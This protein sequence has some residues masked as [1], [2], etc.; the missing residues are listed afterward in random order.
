MKCYLQTFIF[1]FF[2][3][4]CAKVMAPTGGKKD[5]FPPKLLNV[6]FNEKK[7]EKKII[8]TFQFDEYIQL[9][10]FQENIY[11]SP[12]PSSK[13][14]IESQLKGKTILIT[15]NDTLNKNTTYNL[16]LNNC[17]KDLNEGN[18]LDSLNYIFSLSDIADT[19]SLIGEIKDAYSL[20][21]MENTWIMLFEKNVSDSLIFKINPDYIAKSNKN[22][23]FN[24][25]NLKKGDY[26]ICALTDYDFI[27][28]AGEKIAFKVNLLTITTDSSVSLNAFNPIITV[29]SLKKDSLLKDTNS[30]DSIKTNIETG[31]LYINSKNSNSSIF[32]L[33]QNKVVIKE[34][35]F[36]NLPFNLLEVPTGKYQLKHINDIN[37]DG[38]WNAGNWEK[39]QPAEKVTNYPSEIIIRS[40]WD[41]EI[42]WEI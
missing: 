38:K 1:L 32:Q 2:L 40:N 37:N 23:M 27:Y 19:I 33:L 6:N 30:L 14:S 9:N 17:I 21:K 7:M 20:E 31:N 11:L 29:D 10:N 22:G 25:P 3:T 8:L 15:I 12:P 36:T 18:I 5:E 35:S 39:K 26:K 28:D 16:S 41:L 24:F 13:N 34:F 4:S 42:E